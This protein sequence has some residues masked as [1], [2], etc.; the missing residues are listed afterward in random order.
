MQKFPPWRDANFSDYTFFFLITDN[1]GFAGG[2]GLY[3]GLKRSQVLVFDA[4]SPFNFNGSLPPSEYKVNF[5]AGF[6]SPKTIT[7]F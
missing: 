3:K 4:A 2:I 5:K 1:K 7:G 6:C